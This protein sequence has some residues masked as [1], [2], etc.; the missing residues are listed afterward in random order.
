MNTLDEI[1]FRAKAPTPPFFQKLKKIGFIVAAIGTGVLAAPSDLPE[2][3]M[4]WAQHFLT[5]GTVLMT[6]CQL[7]VEENSMEIKSFS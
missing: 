2:V 3:F 5:A 4:T 6:I 1:K 7:V